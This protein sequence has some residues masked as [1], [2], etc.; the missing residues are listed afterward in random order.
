VAGL[1][2]HEAIEHVSGMGASRL[3]LKWPNDLLLDGGKLAGILLEGHWL[4]DARFVVVIGIG[5][6][7]ATAPGGTPYPTSR[8]SDVASSASAETVFFHLAASFARIYESWTEDVASGS[9]NA[10][11]E[12]RLRWLERAA[13]LGS[14]VNVRLPRGELDGIFEGLDSIG[15]LQLTTSRGSE[16]VDAGDLYFPDF[17]PCPAMAAPK[18]LE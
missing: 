10:F 6:N 16:L 18:G 13:G 17:P 2:L 4:P 8:L 11:A 12:I 5:V 3:A 7:I 14:R 9:T 1:A 15:R